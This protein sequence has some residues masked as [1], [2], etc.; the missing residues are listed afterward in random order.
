MVDVQE[1]T[2]EH[3]HDTS[4][5]TLTDCEFLDFFHRKDDD[6]QVEENIGSGG[7]PGIGVQVYASSVL[8][9]IP[10]LPCQPDWY[11]LKCSRRNEC[12]DV[13][14]TEPDRNPDD[15]SKPCLREDAEVE[16]QDRDLS[17]C[18]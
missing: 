11:A 16:E 15:F 13:N 18:D 17:Q 3:E 2:Q 5:A 7:T 10:T 14:Y 6:D 9:A 1:T 12:N 4:L 8:L